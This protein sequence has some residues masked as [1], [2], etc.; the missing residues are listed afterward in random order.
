MPLSLPR[1]AIEIDNSGELA[2]AVAALERA[3]RSRDP[4]FR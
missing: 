1:D 3:L 4:T 2:E